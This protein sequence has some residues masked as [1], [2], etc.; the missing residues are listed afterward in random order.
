MSGGVLE[1]GCG[2]NSPYL[3]RGTDSKM[4]LSILDIFTFSAQYSKFKVS[5]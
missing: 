2:V 4:A 5:K 1:S 3:L